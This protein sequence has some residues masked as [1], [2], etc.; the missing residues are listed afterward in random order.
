MVHTE[1]LGNTLRALREAG[2][3]ITFEE[4][5]GRTPIM[6]HGQ[7]IP[8]QAQDFDNPYLSRYYQG[9]SGGS[10]GAG[11]RVDIDLDHMAA[12]RTQAL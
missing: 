1:G 3:Y 4:F 8:V 5:K 11:T 10:T 7:V 9:E 6:R 2:V 12:V